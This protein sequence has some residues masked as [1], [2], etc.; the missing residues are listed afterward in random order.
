[1]AEEVTVTTMV[2]DWLAGPP[3]QIFLTGPGP[4]FLWRV[5]RWAWGVLGRVLDFLLGGKDSGDSLRRRIQL[6]AASWLLGKEPNELLVEEEVRAEGLAALE[7]A[8]AQLK[9]AEALKAY[10]SLEA[11]LLN[12]GREHVEAVGANLQR[13]ERE[14]V[15]EASAFGKARMEWMD[16]NERAGEQW[17]RSV[18]VFAVMLRVAGDII[19]QQHT[20][21]GG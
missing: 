16:E 18:L 20:R 8:N 1:M 17:L 2:R 4:A 15:D 6:R 9:K 10:I 14:L 19:M 11:A 13:R 12:I 7:K 3:L 5:F 21:R